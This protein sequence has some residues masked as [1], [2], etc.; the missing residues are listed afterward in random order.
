MWD[1]F[2]KFL[3]TPVGSWLRVF[4]LTIGTLWL[5]DMREV[6]YFHVDLSEW[7]PWVL[8]AFAAALP[9]AVAYLNPKD[10]RFGRGAS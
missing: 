7:V 3:T 8:A 6:G 1:A 2:L 5:A 4:V 9:V 10:T